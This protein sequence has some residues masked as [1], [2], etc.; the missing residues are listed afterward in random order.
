M[1]A[2]QQIKI[3]SAS[4]TQKPFE[5]K[6]PKKVAE[7]PRDRKKSGEERKKS[8]ADDIIARRVNIRRRF[9]ILFDW[10]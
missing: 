7:A 1:I 4:I 6:V 8:A 9:V 2:E 3:P 5:E 10:I